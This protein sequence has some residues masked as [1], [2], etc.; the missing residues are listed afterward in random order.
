MALSNSIINI[1]TDFLLAL[2][3][4]PFIWRLQI[5][6]RSKILVVGILSLGLF[7]CVAG[8]IKSTYNKTVLTDPKRFVHDEYSMWNFIEL[9]VGIIAASLPTLKPFFTRLLE[10]ARRPR[11]RQEVSGYDDRVAIPP[12]Q[13]HHTNNWNTP[14]PWKE[15]F[16]RSFQTRGLSGVVGDRATWI[17]DTMRDSEEIIFPLQDVDTNS[18]GIM[19]TRDSK[20]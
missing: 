10:V 2:L 1:T 15:S 7:A 5:E 20:V 8:I 18:S 4:V 6:I 11:S 16:R 17:A 3:P 9:N 19:I 12:Q 13:E 14:R